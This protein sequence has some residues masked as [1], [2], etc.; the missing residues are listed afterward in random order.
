VQH[1]IDIGGTVV[2]WAVVLL[3]LN[4]ALKGNQR[5]LKAWRFAL[6]FALFGTFQIDTVQLGF[7]ALVGLN[8]LGWLVSYIFGSVSI[9]YL[10]AACHRHEMPQWTQPLTVVTILILIAIFPLG[11]ARA[12]ESAYHAIPFNFAELLFMATLYIYGSTLMALI[13]I[14]AIA[15]AYRSERDLTL[16]LRSLAG[17]ASGIALLTFYVTKLT[18]LLTAFIVPRLRPFVG[19]ANTLA[20]IPVLLMAFSWPLLFAPNR[21]YIRLARVVRFFDKAVTL[22][23][24]RALGD[25]LCS[26]RSSNPSWID[27]LR[28]LDFYI[29]QEVIKILD[30]IRI[31]VASKDTLQGDDPA[32]NLALRLHLALQDANPSSDPA[33]AYWELSQLLRRAA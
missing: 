16:R 7:D 11:P 8:N 18:T 6:S 19:A 14:R 20:S 15:Q 4:E 29:C 21:V 13:P 27:Q 33:T 26:T 5:V 23:Q 2:A 24:L 31:L 10:C 9:Y 22:N 17:L 25:R 12:P 30:D 32:L 1:V 28:D 3:R